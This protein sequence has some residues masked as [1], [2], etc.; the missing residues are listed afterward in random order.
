[1]L[2]SLPDPTTI[3]AWQALLALLPAIVAAI[4][5][6]AIRP[7]GTEDR[8]WTIA[9][10][11]SA[12][13]LAAAAASLLLLITGDPGSAFGIR[14]DTVGG[15]V[16][17][18]VAFIAWVIVR[19]SQRYLAGDGRAPRYARWLMVTIA[20]VMT[21]VA[22]NHL[23]VLAL[24]WIVTSLALH[25]LLTFFSDRP[26]AVIAAH[27]KFVV[28]RAA[29]VC[30]LAA[31]GLLAMAFGTLQIDRLLAAAAAQ[32]ELPAAAQIAMLLIALAAMLK[33][34]Q[35]P[36]HGWLIQV[37]EA[38]T[39]VSALLHAGVV[40]LGGFVL[41]RMAPLL[42]EVPAAQVLLV[43]GGAFTAVVA[44]LVMTTRIS[45]KVMLA[46][47]TCAQMG[48]MLMQI[49]LGLPEMAL[50]HLVAHSLYKA[51]A[52]LS[53]GGVVQQ[54]SVRRLAR[55]PAA[56][57][58]AA[59]CAAAL[60]GIVATALAAMAW[61]IAPQMQPALWVLGGIVALAIAPITQGS[62]AARGAWGVLAGAGAAFTLAFVYFGLHALVSGVVHPGLP[63][64][65][66]MLWIFVAAA[67][68]GLFALQ[69]IVTSQPQGRIARALYP[70]FY[71]GLFLDE[72]FSRLLF[73]RW[74]PPAITASP[75]A[76]LEPLTVKA[77]Q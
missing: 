4:A 61:G 29:D 59:Q 7:S 50:L 25:K 32:P 41:I 35:L 70:W 66:S 67:F 55:A 6:W 14:V 62:I 45:I 46:W 5:A 73:S 20:A 19:Y 47:S 69:C 40:N 11:A 33:C 10:S 65:A 22:A 27:K 53:A 17:M 42:A 23:L 8:A 48:F 26:A 34:A 36:F 52:F 30:M 37:M 38:P 9:R 76:T 60:A 1:M 31:V 44:A 24:A 16:A 63:H 64:A 57:S 15:V 13:M 18:L 43:A 75:T 56:T 39:P 72:R 2:A 21:I 77:A 12:A 58:A 74:P 68:V 49:G 28:G 54:A 51:H 71:G 3:P